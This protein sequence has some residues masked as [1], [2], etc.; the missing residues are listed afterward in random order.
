M[1]RHHLA[2]HCS[3]LN[4]A[5]TL[6]NA[7][8]TSGLLIVTGGQ[9]PRA[10]AFGWQSRL[11]AEV[12]K[13]GFPVFRFD[14]RGI[15]D[16][17]GEDRGYLKS[18]KD[19]AAALQSFRALAPQMSRVVG[20]GNCDAATALA[21]AGGAGCDR[22][23]LSNPWTLADHDDALPPASAVRSRYL[24]K[25]VDPSEIWRLLTGG[26]D[27]RKLKNGLKQAS[28]I[29][30]TTSPLTEEMKAG[31]EAFSGQIRFL[32]AENDRTA[33]IFAEHWGPDERI[34]LCSGSGHSYAE[35]HAREW[36]LAQVLEALR[37]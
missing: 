13:A 26:V 18:R 11:A 1:S 2:F 14:R 22:L 27:F 29:G 6:D 10:G 3:G 31:P 4:L 35:P 5:G 21:I 12:A 36:L 34:H 19:I 9:E 37:R 17:D 8:G 16:S 30:T 28:S 7:P 23:V 33:Q 32:L 15:G 20:F 25:L 24:G